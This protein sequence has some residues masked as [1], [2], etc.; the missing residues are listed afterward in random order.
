MSQHSVTRPVSFGIV[1]RCVLTLEFSRL[2][3]P[4]GSGQSA[5]K[6][7]CRVKAGTYTLASHLLSYSDVGLR[8]RHRWTPS[9]TERSLAGE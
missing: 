7:C 9:R 8:K 6:S 5:W 4:T 1:G 3:P 2:H